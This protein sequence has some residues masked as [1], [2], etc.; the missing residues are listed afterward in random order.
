MTDTYM[1]GFSSVPIDMLK[2]VVMTKR[3]TIYR[4]LS[5]M[6]VG[7]ALYSFGLGRLPHD[8]VGGIVGISDRGDRYPELFAHQSMI[9]DSMT[10]KRLRP[11]QF[12]SSVLNSAI[13][14]CSI[15]FNLRGPQLHLTE[16]DD[17]FVYGIRL[18]KQQI[19]HGRADLMV[20]LVYKGSD[21]LFDRKAHA[22]VLIAAELSNMTGDSLKERRNP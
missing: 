2:S 5:E 8:L 10:D 19:N 13:G 15:V 4:K 17:A 6:A 20:V 18:A 3:D 11:H 14:H 7:S 1:S 21:G 16:F 12:G 9:I 22:G